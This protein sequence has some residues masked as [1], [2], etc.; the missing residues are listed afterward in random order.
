[1]HFL[2]FNLLPLGLYG[3]VIKYD[4]YYIMY[5]IYIGFLT[6]FIVSNYLKIYQNSIQFY[7]F[8]LIAKVIL[9]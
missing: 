1:M 8:I 9:F 3:N 5:I 6:V 2:L 7:R 4:L